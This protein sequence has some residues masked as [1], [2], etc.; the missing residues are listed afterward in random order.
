MPTP[1]V[2]DGQDKPLHGDDC[3]PEYKLDR[4]KC[5]R[6]TEHVEGRMKLEI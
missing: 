3:N 4:N 5:E 2:D 1:S 6:L